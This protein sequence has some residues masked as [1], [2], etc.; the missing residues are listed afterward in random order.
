MLNYLAS[1]NPSTEVPSDKM[2]SSYCD[3]TNDAMT[4]DKCFSCTRPVSYCFSNLSG[5]KQW[6]C[7]Y[8][9]SYIATSR[10]NPVESIRIDFQSLKINS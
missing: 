2:P 6:Y 7:G 1:L 4:N 10:S 3:I 9:A 8:C 5:I